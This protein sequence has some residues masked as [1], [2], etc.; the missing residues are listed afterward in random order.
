MKSYLWFLLVI[1]PYTH[2]CHA[3]E[4]N[5]GTN[6]GDTRRWIG[7]D[8]LAMPLHD[9]HLES[10]KIIANPGNFGGISDRGT[11]GARLHLTTRLVGKRG[12]LETSFGLRLKKSGSGPQK[13]G[14]WLGLKSKTPS[15][16]NVW[17]HPDET[18]AYFIGI[19]DA[20]NVH[21]GKN[22][23]SLSIPGS[24]V[25]AFHITA[26]ITSGKTIVKLVA[27]V[28][29]G[30][31]IEAQ[32]T[33]AEDT[34]FGY[35]CL[36][37]N[38]TD[39]T[40]EFDAWQLAGSALDVIPSD[41]TGPII[42]TQ[43]TL[44]QQTVKLQAQL[45]PLEKTDEQEAFLDLKEEGQW[46]QVARADIEVFSSTAAFRLSNWDDTRHVEYRVRYRWQG[47]E[48][49]WRGTI[50]SNPKDRNEFSLGVFNCDHGELFPQN[51]MVR[52]VRIQNP[53]MLFF[54]GDQIYENMDY[55]KIVRQPLEGAR[56]SYFTKWYQFGLTWR[57]LLK[58]RPSAI[59]PDD[60]DVFMGNV[61]G[62]NGLGYVMAPEWV[63]MI[64]QTQTGSLPDPVDPRP[65]KRGIEVYFTRV[66]Y[67][68]MSFAIMEDRKFKSDPGIV[69]KEELK[70]STGPALDR[71]KGTLLGKR[72]LRFLRDWNEKTADLPV[73]WFLS[74]TMF[75]KAST[76]SGDKLKR[77]KNSLDPNGWPQTARNRALKTIGRDVIMV[78]GDQHL[79]MLARMGV[80]AYDDGPYT[81][82]FKDDLGNYMTVYGVTNPDPLPEG[83][84][85]ARNRPEV[86]GLGPFEVQKVKGS[87]HG[88]I[89]VD[90]ALATARFEAYTLDF[91]ASSPKASDQFSGF[92]YTIQLH[93]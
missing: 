90:K 61:W 63:N 62:N 34:L 38:G 9:W 77:K 23:Y 26:Q 22:R 4:V 24:Q 37:A 3:F 74:Q 39:A 10:G 5:D 79:G 47:K 17:I 73:R 76:H 41:A 86:A 33:L 32:D 46:K 69:T 1:S 52:N 25:V 80:D 88:L 49:S 66:D 51:T 87:G 40:W 15:P 65:V 91:D 27:E 60:H 28:A 7:P 14:L 56:L 83:V 78:H 21:M 85:D 71:P 58:D 82:R 64:Q 48:Y 75:V 89:I 59:I 70:N 44:S 45:V 18:G 57:S 11:L 12:Y 35:A 93:E 13:A 72:Q 68:G 84:D 92:P 2:P 54:A 43:Y 16:Q 19:D 50:R 29:G 36:S 55:F 6:P 53:D 30:D 42:W 8:Y 20:G 31:N 67:A 81:G